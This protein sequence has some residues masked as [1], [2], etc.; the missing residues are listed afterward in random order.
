MDHGAVSVEPFVGSHVEHVARHDPAF[1]MLL[2]EWQDE[3]PRRFALVRERLL[4][5]LDQVDDETDRRLCGWYFNLPAEARAAVSRVL[6]RD[7]L[8]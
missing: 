8:G 3:A 1:A 6:G 5:V 4:R 2:E 7:K